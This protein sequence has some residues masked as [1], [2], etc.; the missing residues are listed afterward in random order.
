LKVCDHALGTLPVAVNYDNF[1]GEASHH[2][3]QE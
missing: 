1:A 3:A 2:H